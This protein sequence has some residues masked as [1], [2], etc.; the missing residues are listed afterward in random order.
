[1]TPEPDV[2]ERFREMPLDQFMD[3]YPDLESILQKVRDAPMPGDN[4]R[5]GLAILVAAF[6]ASMAVSA[7]END[8]S[9][10]P[11]ISDLLEILKRSLNKSFP[12]SS[13]SGTLQ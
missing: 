4:A 8:D 1:M 9:E 6:F 11:N 13:Q 7:M 12:E 5:A 10:A 3:M 2:S